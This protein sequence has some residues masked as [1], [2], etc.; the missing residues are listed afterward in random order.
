MAMFAPPPWTALRIAGLVIAIASLI[1]LTVARV[2]L[3]NSFSVMPEARQL[4][5][6]GIYSRI[7]NPIYV[8]SAIGLAA[9]CLYVNMPV[10][11]LGLLVLVPIQY[12]RARAEGRVL[13]TRFAE[14]YRQYKSATWF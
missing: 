13:E 3:G 9:L 1:L 7:R 11:L 5:T 10:L 12:F 14:E 8:F 6:R 4:V 2:Q